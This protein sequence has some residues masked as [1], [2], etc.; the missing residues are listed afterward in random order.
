MTIE[1]ERVRALEE[2]LKHLAD[3]VSRVTKAQDEHL[4]SCIDEN[5]KRRHSESELKE[6]VRS[7]IA[8]IKHDLLSLTINVR[9]LTGGC[10]VIGGGAVL[11]AMD[12]LK[13]FMGS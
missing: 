9:W 7:S 2:Q 11:Y 4:K 6:L 12:I 3:S 1:S 8:D 10:T 13:L 5:A